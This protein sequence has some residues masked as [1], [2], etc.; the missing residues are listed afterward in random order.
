MSDLRPVG[1]PVTIEGVERHFLFTLNVIDEIQERFDTALS[2]VLGKLVEE[3]KNEKLIY[4]VTT[5][6]NDEARREKH[7][8]NKELK[9]YTEQEIG[10]ILDEERK[11]EFIVAILS[12]YGVSLP[13]P[14]EDTDPN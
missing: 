12:A 5:L 3:R 6:L 1:V 14:D 9:V 13:E 2:E 7:F 11:V 8:E 10:W 4:L